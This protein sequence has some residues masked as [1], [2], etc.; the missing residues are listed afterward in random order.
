MSLKNSGLYCLTL[1]I[2]FSGFIQAE[3]IPEGFEDVFKGIE[4]KK[5][6]H[7]F[8][9]PVIGYSLVGTLVQAKKP[10]G[11]EATFENIESPAFRNEYYNEFNVGYVRYAPPEIV[12]QVKTLNVDV[13]FSQL[14]A[15]GSLLTS[16]SSEKDTESN[17]GKES[18]ASPDP[19][20]TALASD[21]SV[22]GVDFARFSK[23]TR[24]I[25]GLSVEYYT[26]KT[27]KDIEKRAAVNVDGA[28]WLTKENKG[29]IIHRALRIDGMEYHLWSNKDIDAG[30]L[31]KLV[32]WLPG[33]SF[34]RINNRQIKLITE[35]P[36]YVG[37]K[38]WRPDVDFAGASADALDVHSLGDSEIGANEIDEL[39]AGP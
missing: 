26:L 4:P 2:L 37:Y 34:R 20:S 9:P 12:N 6:F 36:I 3:K 18:P 27:L 17:S 28:A 7:P 16:S 1:I 32:R 14:D 23:V 15:I 21:R 39:L 31:A 33:V 5:R 11:L 19:P 22:T 30:F 13:S 10:S 8:W 35:F 38:L 25:N 24:K 29:W